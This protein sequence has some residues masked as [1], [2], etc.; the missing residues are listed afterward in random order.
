MIHIEDLEEGMT[1]E[2]W[3]VTCNKVIGLIITNTVGWA[4]HVRYLKP[5]MERV[6]MVPKDT[7]HLRPIKVLAY[8]IEEAQ[9]KWPEWFI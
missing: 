1:V 4:F 2:F 6:Q 3:D 8:T 9:D 5:S 7:D